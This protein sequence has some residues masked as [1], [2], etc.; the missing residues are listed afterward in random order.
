MTIQASLFD[1]SNLAATVEIPMAPPLVPHQW[2]FPG[3]TPEDSARAAIAGSEEYADMLAAVIQ[4]EG[5]A[6][7]IGKQVLA[8]IP[9]DWR[10]LC[11]KYAHGSIGWTQGEKRGIKTDYV[12]HDG[13]G[14]HFTYQAIEAESTLQRKAA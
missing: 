11:G 10:E 12:T 3:M 2:P 8:L 14:H 9:S 6:T 7:L 4:R 13:G 1:A 5:G